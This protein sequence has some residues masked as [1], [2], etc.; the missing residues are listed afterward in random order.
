VTSVSEDGIQ[1]QIAP[2][3]RITIVRTAVVGYQG[4]TP[5]ADQ[6]A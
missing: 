3:V 5:V 1:L 4:Q 6:S 2:S